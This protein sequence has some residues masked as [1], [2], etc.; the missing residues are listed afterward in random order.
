MR[1]IEWPGYK[2]E[3]ARMVMVT[4]YQHEMMV[5]WDERDDQLDGVSDI[6]LLDNEVRENTV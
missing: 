1:K 5:M 6:V 4:E 3:R 2:L